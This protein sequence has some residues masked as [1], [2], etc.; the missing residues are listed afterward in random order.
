MYDCNMSAFRRRARF[1]TPVI[2]VAAC[3]SSKEPTKPQQFPG[4]T[5]SV[6]M[7]V[8]MKCVA[9]KGGESRSIECPPGMSGTTVF[10]IGELSTKTCGIVPTGCASERCVKIPAPCPLPPGVQAVQKLA[11]VWTIEK[12]GDACHA[13]EGEGHDACPPGV[14][15]NPPQPRIVKCPPGAT[16]TQELRIAELVDG[17]CVRVPDG[18]ETTGCATQRIDCLVTIRPAGKP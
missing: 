9:T 14:D 12:R 16:E 17:T 2:V 6:R 5:W 10:T 1:A 8:D 15:C 13:E 7:L 11:V 4:V 18:C 3:S